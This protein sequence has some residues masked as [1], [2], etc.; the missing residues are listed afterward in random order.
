MGVVLQENFQ[1][2]II[3]HDEKF[4][5][6]LGAREYTEDYFRVSKNDHNQSVIRKQP[7]F[8]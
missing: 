3:T 2:I 6:L 8:D 5:S 4:V 1:L 7:F